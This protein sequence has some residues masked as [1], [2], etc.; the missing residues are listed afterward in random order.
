MGLFAWLGHFWF[1]IIQ[2]ATSGTELFTRRRERI[3]QSI[4]NRIIF[5]QRHSELWRRH[6]SNP[7]LH[8]VK[9]ENVDLSITPV[10]LKEN[11][12]VTE[13]INHFS[14]CFEAHTRGVFNMP[15]A[16][17]FDIKTFFALPIP[18]VVWSTNQKFH[19]R[20]FIAFVERHLR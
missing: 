12:F 8:R 5:T 1:E 6:A 16:I 20:K 3:Y 17:S 9:R 18:E 10:T 14:D 4:T 15:E 7:D 11:Q 13:V 2:S 19:D